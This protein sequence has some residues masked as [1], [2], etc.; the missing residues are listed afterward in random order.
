MTVSS[1]ALLDPRQVDRLAKLLGMLGSDRDGEVVNA[2]RAADRLVRSAGL[3]WFDVIALPAPSIVP[4]RGRDDD[5]RQTV[6]FCMARA[7]Q[8]SP[9][10]RDFVWSMWCWRGQ[11]TEK[12]MRWLQDIA[13]RPRAAARL[14][15]HLRR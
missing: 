1:S 10:E 3:T 7:H 15:Q 11:P 12:Q 5:W 8:L 2:G 4:G 6:S 14:V 13:A 9:R